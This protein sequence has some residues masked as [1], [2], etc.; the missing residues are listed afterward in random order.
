MVK[1]LDEVHQTSWDRK[2][3]EDQPK[4]AMPNA[5][6]RSRH[7]PKDQQRH[8]STDLPWKTISTSLTIKVHDVLDKLAARDEPVLDAGRVFL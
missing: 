2:G 6:E 3:L 1:G 4:P 8:E 5:W 7:V